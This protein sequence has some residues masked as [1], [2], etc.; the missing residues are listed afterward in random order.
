MDILIFIKI[1]VDMGDGFDYLLSVGNEEWFFKAG[2]KNETRRNNM[3]TDTTAL[4]VAATLP[5]E[6][7][8]SLL[9]QKQSQKGIDRLKAIVESEDPAHKEIKAAL[10]K[11]VKVW[12]RLHAP[13]KAYTGKPRGRKAKTVTTTETAPTVA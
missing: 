1:I 12:D 7:L 6:V 2:L 3:S 5:T 11:K 13:K 10:L 9:Q 4:E 8:E